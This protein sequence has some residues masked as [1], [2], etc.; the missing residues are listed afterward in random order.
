MDLNERIDGFKWQNGWFCSDRRMNE[1]NVRMH[2]LYFRGLM[3]RC[4]H[5]YGHIVRVG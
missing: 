3:D 4:P 2:V 5:T 1:L